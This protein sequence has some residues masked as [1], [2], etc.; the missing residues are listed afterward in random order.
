MQGYFAVK[1]FAFIFARGGS[2]GVP[3]KNIRSLAGKPLLVHSIEIAKR[4]PS[5]SKILVSTDSHEIAKVGLENGAEI[6]LRPDELARDDSPEW[7]AWRHAINW[8]NDRSEDFDV[9]LSLPAT[10]PLR[11][12]SDIESCLAQLDHETDIVVTMTETTRSPWFNMVR[13]EG[14]YIRLLSQGGGVYTRRQDAPKGF[15]MTTVAYVMRPDFILNA[16]NIFEGRVK[17]VLI[18]NERAIDIDTEM[19]FLLAEILMKKLGDA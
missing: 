9:F 4:V 3:G 13:Q 6:I 11:N 17:G 5:I 7:E 19:D 15:D 14:N 10:S 18:P 12:V 2:K 16:N 1:T 8:L